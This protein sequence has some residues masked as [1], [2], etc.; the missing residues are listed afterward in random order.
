MCISDYGWPNSFRNLFPQHLSNVAFVKVQ[1]IE[2][3]IIVQVIG[4]EPSFGHIKN[5]D[6]I[7]ALDD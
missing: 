1:L 3:W 6:I 7:L 5:S 2:I 4:P